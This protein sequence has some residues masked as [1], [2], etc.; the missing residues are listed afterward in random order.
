MARHGAA[1]SD[2]L[3]R[4]QYGSHVTQKVTSF[5][6]HCCRRNSAAFLLDG[7]AGKASSL[8][9]ESVWFDS[10]VERILRNEH[11]REFHGQ[12]KITSNDNEN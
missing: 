11:L 1:N 6:N 5:I 8:H 7:P 10:I 9:L 3:V 12:Q 2:R 4:F